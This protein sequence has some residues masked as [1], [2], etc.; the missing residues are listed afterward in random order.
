MYERTNTCA[1]TSRPLLGQ[2]ENFTL[3]LSLAPPRTHT[4]THARTPQEL[5]PLLAENADE[6][7]R[8]AA[9]AVPFAPGYRGSR[10]KKRERERLRVVR[11]RW[12]CL[13]LHLATA[14]WP[15]VGLVGGWVGGWV[16]A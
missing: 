7:L 14:V 3:W 8:E 12:V 4:R 5:R 6:L 2:F 9:E 11:V 16:G 15:C 13:E 10:R 1:H